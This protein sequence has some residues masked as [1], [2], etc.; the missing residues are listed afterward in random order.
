MKVLI[1]SG[2]PFRNDTNTGKTLMTLFADLNSDEMLQLYF[3]PETPNVDRCGSYYRICEKEIVKSVLGIRKNIC[4]G[5]VLPVKE[6]ANANKPE[7]NVRFITKYKT[8]ISVRCAREA[9]WKYSLWENDNLGKWIADEKPDVIFAVMLDTNIS[10]KIIRKM[11]DKTGCPVVLFVTDD[12][13][14]DCE[15]SNSFIR[16]SYYK[17]RRKLYSKLSANINTLVGCS[18]KATEYFSK[19]FNIPDA[20]TIYTP[21][22][23][24]CFEMPYREQSN[25]DIVKIRYFG[26]LGLGRWEILKQLGETVRQINSNGVKAIL[27]VYSSVT[28]SEIINALSIENGCV[29]KGWVYGDEYLKLLQS[30]DIAVHVESFDDAMIRRT[31]ASIST[32]IADYLGAGKCILAI[33]SKDLAS[34]EHIK[35]VSCAVNDMGLL[36]KKLESLIDD[37][38]IRTELQYRA[39]KLAEKEHNMSSIKAHMRK[40]LEDA[41]K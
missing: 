4:G 22:A 20:E 13:Y 1:I 40:I 29:Y 2:T 5:T 3:S 37:S 39:R 35:D 24:S 9:L 8:N 23:D 7:T 25:N 14:N 38:G 30:A 21:S 31:W 41:V 27:E 6:G 15:K 17:K 19:E 26:N 32:K 28:D 33:G 11:S 16:K 34:M 18:S 12:Y 36:R 10:A